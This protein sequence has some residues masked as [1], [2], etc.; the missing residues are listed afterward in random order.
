M[1]F[2]KMGA[3]AWL[4]LA[5]FTLVSLAGSYAAAA[6]KQEITDAKA[7]LA[8]VSMKMSKL[9]SY[10]ATTAI[11]IDTPFGKAN[12]TNLTDI[13]Q[14]DVL[15][16][17]V[18]DVVL[19][20]PK[21]E[22]QK[23]SFTQY[24]QQNGDSFVVYSGIEGQW[25]KQTATVKGM[26]KPVSS[27]DLTS[28]LKLVKTAKIKDQTADEI[29]L[30]VT[31]DSAQIME[32]ILR[33]VE[34]QIKDQRQAEQAKTVLGSIGD[35]SYLV[36]VDKRTGYVM[37]TYIDLSENVRNVLKEL[38]SGV[39]PEGNQ[40]MASAMIGQVRFI[41]QS[42][43]SQFNQVKKFK[44]PED[45]VKNAVEKPLGTKEASAIGVIGGAEGQALPS[46]N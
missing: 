37:N 44:I 30:D 42:D 38:L 26:S 31:I 1:R 3:C 29:T 15:V 13:L 36:H 2:W 25:I 21:R 32:Q 14:P 35:I 22:Q 8:E 6:E 41:I 40:E 23:G 34:K 16:K 45:V 5:V 17:S 19:T 43:N 39:K 4:F 20:A 27:A 28:A 10:H 24:I 9:K 7:Y 11:D 46:G 12:V 33:E 18:S